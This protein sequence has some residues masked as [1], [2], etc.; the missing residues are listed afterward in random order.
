MALEESSSFQ[1]ESSGGLKSGWLFCPTGSTFFFKE[2]HFKLYV[3]YE[4]WNVLC[5][6]YHK[7]QLGLPRYKFISSLISP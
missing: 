5:V 3:N 4:N 6:K 2:R 1:N 7:L